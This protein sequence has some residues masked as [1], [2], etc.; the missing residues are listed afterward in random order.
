MGLRWA[1]TG[2]GHK[3]QGALTMAIM[4]RCCCLR[5]GITT[6]E[7]GQ[8]VKERPTWL[9]GVQAVEGEVELRQVGQ[10]GDGG[11]DLREPVRDGQVPQAC[12]Q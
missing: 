10:A 12:S 11:R 8:R 9:Q 4:V 5:S 7:S 2:C 1:E 6:L 3:D